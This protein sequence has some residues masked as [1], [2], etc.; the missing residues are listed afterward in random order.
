MSTVIRANGSTRNYVYKTIRD[1]IINWEI[2][3]GQK[4]S[5]KEVSEELSV[6]RTP[7]REAFLQLAQ[8][9]LLE[10]YPQIG[11]VV[12]KIDFSLVEEAR[13]VR[14]TIERAIV[15]D[16]CENV[17]EDFI[18]EM[19]TNV[20][21]QALCI[22]KGTH[23]RLFELD[24]QFHYLLYKE[25]KKIRTWMFIRQMNGHF[26]RLRS[27][28]LASDPNWNLIVNQHK[29]IF[30]NIMKK[31]PAGAEATMGSHLLLVNS[32][33]ESLKENYSNYFKN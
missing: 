31:D 10:I 4:I 20:T 33:K 7:V 12:S 29:E 13:F 2:K 3:P 25:N 11:T 21:M 17:S 16:L 14:E 27:L 15:R 23:K 1:K 32:E 28:R 24:Q 5:E 26:D 8:E 6:S 9:D 19:E 18:F 22:E 30:E